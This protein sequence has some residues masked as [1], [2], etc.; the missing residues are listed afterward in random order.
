MYRIGSVKILE[1]QLNQIES[2]H[3]NFQGEKNRGE[4]QIGET[5]FGPEREEVKEKREG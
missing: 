1:I 4:S 2:F 5:R 3:S